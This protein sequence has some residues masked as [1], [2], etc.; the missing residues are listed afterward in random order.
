MVRLMNRATANYSNGKIRAPVANRRKAS[1][2]VRTRRHRGIKRRKTFS[3]ARSRDGTAVCQGVRD[4]E[5]TKKRERKDA[6]LDGAGGVKGNGKKKDDRNAS[7]MEREMWE[8][9][10]NRRRARERE[11]RERKR[12]RARVRI[13][14]RKSESERDGEGRSEKKN[15]ARRRTRS[16][17]KREGEGRGGG[18]ANS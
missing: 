7:E 5:K 9:D 4:D 15:G 1:F 2:C 11:R 14:N 6:M 8:K 13:T 3:A 10:G 17:G 12:A 18:G 16:P